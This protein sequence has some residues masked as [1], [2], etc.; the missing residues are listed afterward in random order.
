MLPDPPA[1]LGRENELTA[2]H[3]FLD[4][5]PSGPRALL[6][7]GDAGIGK[8]TMWTAAVSLARANSFRILTSR[9]AE[10]EARLSYAALAD[11]LE[12]ATSGGLRFAIAERS[13]CP[14]DI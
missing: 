13:P 12:E 5:V 4:D 3:A 14:V 11:L 9:P 10:S 7:E 1:F 8:T 2:L 6:L